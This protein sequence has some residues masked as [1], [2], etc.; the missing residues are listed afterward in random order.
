MG[1]YGT[2]PRTSMQ[3][4]LNKI[5]E[6][7]SIKRYLETN[8]GFTQMESKKLGKFINRETQGPDEVVTQGGSKGTKVNRIESR[9][10]DKLKA[11]KE[12]ILGH[13]DLNAGEPVNTSKLSKNLKSQRAREG[14]VPTISRNKKP[15]NDKQ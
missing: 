14:V 9:R 12:N 3:S 7:S 1:V 10:L 8:G 6:G 2:N 11:Q 15:S 13:L 4:N 5:G